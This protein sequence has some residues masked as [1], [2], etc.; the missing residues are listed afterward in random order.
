ME[1]KIMKEINFYLSFYAYWAFEGIKGG[2][3]VH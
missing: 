1:L 3:G 2:G